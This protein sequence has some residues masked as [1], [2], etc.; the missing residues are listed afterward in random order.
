MGN[1]ICN[2]T[3]SVKEIWKDVK[4][5]EGLYQV[6]NFG[7]VKSVER[8]SK[9]GKKSFRVIKEKILAQ[10]KIGRNREYLCV[11]L[12]KNGISKHILIHR[13]VAK[14]F[15]PNPNNYQQVNHKN[16]IK[17][18]NR[19]ENLEWC[20]NKYNSNYGCRNIKISKSNSKKVLCVET[21]II[22]SN[23]IQASKETN[24]YQGDISKCANKKKTKA[25]GYHWKYV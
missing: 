24:A 7:K 10:T 2:R 15:I 12:S 4:E 20:D 18:D 5:Y 11:K 21:N 23:T 3:N 16:E 14:S 13:I 1:L 8:K 25:G 22:Y 9:N 19:V 17:T 6:S